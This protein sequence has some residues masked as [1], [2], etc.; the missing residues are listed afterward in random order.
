MRN[1]GLTRVILCAIICLLI[2]LPGS[3]ST[4]T[5]VVFGPQKY[6]RTTGAAD[7]YTAS[8]SIPKGV[9]SPFVLHVQNGSSYG[10]DRVSSGTVEIDGATILSQSDFNQQV[11]QFD[12]TVSLK[13][14]SVLRVLLTSSPGSYLTIWID[15]QR[16]D[17]TPPILKITAPLDASYVSKVTPH[18]GVEYSDLPGADEAAASG[19]D[20]TSLQVLL[21]GVNR[22]DWFTVRP[23]D[24]T[25]DVALDS[26]LSTGTHTL[27]V[28]IKDI[29]GN[30]AKTSASFRIDTTAPQISFTQPSQPWQKITNPTIALSYQDD[31][32]IDLSSLRVTINGEDRTSWFSVSDSSAVANLAPGALSNGPVEA[33]ATISDAAGN[34]SSTTLKFN[35]DIVK[36]SLTILHPS[37]GSIHASNSIDIAIA[38]SDDQA[39]DPSTATLTLDGSPIALQTGPM[40]AIAQ[41][42]TVADGQDHT[43]IAVVRDKAGNEATATSKFTVDTTNPDIHIVRPAVDEFSKTTAVT[44][45]VDYS[46]ADNVNPG[47]L[48]VLVNGIDR[49]AL[50]A[51]GSSSATANLPPGMLSDGTVVI[52][53]SVH[54]AAGNTGTTESHFVID[55]VAPAIS[56]QSPNSIVN[57]GA[58][59]IGVAY[60]DERSGV[61]LS[62]LRVSLDGQG[63]T[64]QLSIGP[65]EA[66]GGFTGLGDSSHTVS[67]SIKDKAGNQR[68]FSSSFVVDTVAPKIL[69]SAPVNDSFTNATAGDVNAAFDDQGGS[70]IVKSSVHAYLKHGDD[71]EQE[72]TDSLQ[73]SE[74]SLSGRL[75]AAA[76]LADGTYKLRIIA[77]DKATNPSESVTSFDVDT[78][79]PQASLESP[80]PDTS[81]SSK[82]PKITI[83]YRDDNSGVDLNRLAIRVDGN[84]LTS[85]FNLGLT[86]AVGELLPE[87][88]LA[89]GDH[90][91]DVALVDLAGNAGAVSNW[92]FR[93]DTVP[94]NLNSSISPAP[95]A[96]GWNNTDVVVTFA[97]TDP[98]DGISKC[99]DPVSVSTEGAGQSISGTAVDSA[100][101]QTILSVPVSIDRT[102]PVI[103]AVAS[104]TPN[105]AGWNNAD[106]T[107]TFTC[108]DAL[109]G[110]AACTQ[111]LSVVQ[112]SSANTVSGAALDVAG[113]TASAQVVVKLD[114]TPPTLQPVLSPAANAAGW[115]NTDVT[116]GFDCHDTLSGVSNCTGPL[117]ISQEDPG[118]TVAGSASD[119][120]GNTATTSVVVRIDKTPPVIHAVLSPL[121]NVAGWNNRDV[122]VSFECS[123]AESGVQTCPSPILISNDGAGQSFT[124]TVVDRAG[125]TATASGTVNIAKTLPLITAQL[126]PAPNAEGWN[127]ADVTVSFICSAGS[128]PISVCPAPVV[129]STEGQAQPVSGTVVD[130]AGNMATA[131][132]QVSIDKTPPVVTA[133]ATPPANAAGWNNSDVSVSYTCLDSLSGV[134]S[135]P[136]PITVNTE[137]S[138]QLFKQ[139]VTDRA[140]NAATVSTTINLDKTAPVITASTHPGPNSNGW[141]NDTVAVEFGCSDSLSGVAQCPTPMSVSAEGQ[142]QIVTGGAI[143]AAGNRAT[144]SAAV[145][146]DRT[147]PTV[148]VAAPNYLTRTTPAQI[149]VSADDNFGIGQMV[150]SVNGIVL[151][152]SSS[153]SS[154]FLLTVPSGAV[155]GD[156][157]NI[158]V[159]ATDLAGNTSTK[160][161]G[162]RVTAD[163]V[164]AGQVLSDV[165][166]LPLANARVEI[167]GKTSHDI[168][169]NHGRYSLSPGDLHVTLQIVSPDPNTGA[170][171]T[172]TV[173]RDVRIQAGAGVVPID[174]RLTPIAQPVTIPPDGKTITSGKLTLFIPGG[175]TG[176]VQFTPLSSQ[177]LPGLLPLGWSPVASWDVR[178]DGN[179][180][181]TL[182]ATK[183]ANGTMYLVSYSYAAHSWLMVQPNIETASDGSL[184]V[185][186][187]YSGTYALVVPDITDPPIAIAGV[188]QALVGVDF[189]TIPESVASNGVLNPAVLPPT[190]G[191]STATLSLQSAT[192]LPSGTVLQSTVAETYLPKSGNT[193]ATD[194]RVQDVVLYRYGA[195]Q[196]A[197]LGSAFPVT[198]SKTFQPADLISGKV[199]LDILAGRENVRGVPGGNDAVVVQNGDVTLTV[200]A[201]SLPQDTAVSVAPSEIESYLPSSSSVQALASI[202]VDF[203]GEILSSSAQL[204]IAA[205]TGVLDSDQLVVARVDRSI[206]AP[207]LIVVSAAAQQN[208]QLV[209]VV[210]AALPGIKQSGEYVFYRIANPIG[211]VAGAVRSSS[212]PV[213]AVVS[214]DALPF[215]FTTA[216]DGNFKLPAQVGIVKLTALVL[217]TALSG[218]AQTSV[219]AGQTAVQD[220]VVAGIVYVAQVSPADGTTRVATSTSII[221]TAPVAIAPNSVNLTNIQLSRV[222][223]QSPMAVRTILSQSG[224]A[225]SVIPSQQL[226]SGVKYAFSIAGLTDAVGAYISVPTVSFTTKTEVLPTFDPSQITF[227]YPDASGYVHISAPPG[228]F[229]PGTVIT[230]I[231]AGNGFVLSLT[232][233][234]D[235]SVSADM[236]ATI[237]DLLN[238]TVTDPLGAKSSF[239][240]SQFVAADGT[241]AVSSGGGT[242]SGPG[243]VELRIAPGTLDHAATFKITSFGPEAFED[244]PNTTLTFGG[245]LR[246]DANGQFSF[247]K[248]V[249]LAFPKPAGAPDNAVYFVFR[250]LHGDD[251]SILYETIDEAAVEGSGDAA[252]VVT[253]SPPHEGFVNLAT[254]FNSLTQTIQQGG[255]SVAANVEFLLEYA[256]DVVKSNFYPSGII[257]GRVRQIVNVPGQSS[258]TYTPVARALVRGVNEDLTQLG[259]KK[260]IVAVTQDNGMFTLWDESFHGGTVPLSVSADGMQP[261]TLNVTAYEVQQTDDSIASEVRGLINA[262]FGK[263][264]NVAYVDATYPAAPPKAPA[265]QLQISVLQNSSSGPPVLLQ[266]I[267]VA[268]T[269]LTIQV[270]ST[271]SDVVNI[272][273][274]DFFSGLSLSQDV[275]KG[276]SDAGGFVYLA[277]YLV[278][279]A[280]TF[281][282][283]ATS[284]PAFGGSAVIATYDF[285][286]VG[287]GQTPSNSTASP[288][289][290]TVIA[291][292]PNDSEEQIDIHVNPQVVFSEPVKNVS[293]ATVHVID[294]GGGDATPSCPA[295]VS[296]QLPITLTGI[297]KDGLAIPSLASSTEI[298]SLV[299]QPGQLLTYGH[300]YGVLL[301]QT[302]VDTDTDSNGAPAPKHLQSAVCIRIK[303]QN[304][305][306]VQGPTGFLSPGIFVD[307]NHAFV[308]EVD[309]DLDHG[310]A[311]VF[312]I[313]DPTHPVDANPSL[314]AV[315]DTFG[316]LILGRPMAIAGQSNS[317]VFSGTSQPLIAVAA[318]SFTYPRPSNVHLYTMN[319]AGTPI[320]VAAVSISAGPLDGMVND[321]AVKDGRVFASVWRKGIQVIDVQQAMLDYPWDYITHG[322]VPI[323]GYN[324]S[325]D[326]LFSGMNYQLYTE[327]KGFGTD[328]VVDTIPIVP[329]SAACQSPVPDPQ[330]PCQSEEYKALVYRIKTDDYVVDGQSGTWVIGAGYVQ[331]GSVEPS[332]TPTAA[333]VT[334]DSLSNKVYKTSPAVNNM[335]M[336]RAYVLDVASI[337][338]Q[339][340]PNLRKIAV[341]AG[342][343]A[344]STVLGVLQMDDPRAP[345]TLSLIPI[346]NEV[347][348]DLLVQ[349]TT[350]IVAFQHHVEFYD[351]T[352][353]YAPT[354]VGSVGNDSNPFGGHLAFNDD[355]GFLFSTNLN[356]SNLQDQPGLQ[357]AVFKNYVVIGYIPP[358]LS[359]EKSDGSSSPRKYRQNIVR[360]PISVETYPSTLK[361]ASTGTVMFYAGTRTSCPKSPDGTE[362]YAATVTLVPGS[363]THPISVPEQVFSSVAP[364]SEKYMTACAVVPGGSSLQPL[365]VH[366][367]PFTLGTVRVYADMNNDTKVDLSDGARDRNPS[368]SD[369]FA[370]W[371]SNPKN[372]PTTGT[373]TSTVDT[374]ET[375]AKPEAL[376]DYATLVVEAEALPPSG[377]NFDFG[378]SIQG[379]QWSV[380]SKVATQDD[381][382]EGPE[383]T[384]LEPSHVALNKKYLT[385]SATAQNQ[386]DAIN[387]GNS[388]CSTPQSTAPKGECVSNGPDGFI[389]LK[390]LQ[391]GDNVLL[392]RCESCGRAGTTNQQLQVVIKPSS[393]ANLVVSSINADLRPLEKWYTAY[394]VRGG[395]DYRPVPIAQKLEGYDDVPAEA[396]SITV[397]VHGFNVSE[398]DAT[399]NF[400]PTYF[401]RLY[402]AEHPVHT[403]QNGGSPTYVVGFSWSGDYL[404]SLSQETAAYVADLLLFRGDWSHSLHFPDDEMRAFESGVALAKL[405]HTLDADGR[406]L[407][408]VAHSLGNMVVNSA[409]TRTQELHG[410]QIANYVM[411]E[412]AV[413]TEAFAQEYVP[414]IEEST[415]MLPGAA[416]YGYAPP[417]PDGTPST[418]VDSRW[419]TDWSEMW[420][421]EPH[422]IS[423]D[424]FDFPDFAD[425]QDWCTKICG[426]SDLNVCANPVQARLSCPAAINT[427]PLPQY[428]Y[429]WS[430]VRPGGY[431]GD[432]PDTA[433]SNSPPQR[434]PWRGF[435]GKNRTKTRMINTFNT[436]DSVL[437]SWYTNR[438]IIPQTGPLGLFSDSRHQNFWAKLKNTGSEEDAI[439]GDGLTHSNIVRQWAELAYWF[440]PL[441][442]P[443]GSGPVPQIESSGGIN[444][445]LTSFGGTADESHSYLTIRTY[446]QVF[447]GWKKVS[448]YLRGMVPDCQPR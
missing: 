49:S 266:G 238:I 137:A 123:D 354:H 219:S 415:V 188:G 293:S 47:T 163:G 199:H 195:P 141:N 36:P 128:A 27:A 29:A 394:S 412:G 179:V 62:T 217:N 405:L 101:N 328:A 218:T 336:Q 117:T 165:T 132:V 118:W 212:G 404:S 84:N 422:R 342:T 316:G 374:R 285:R 221:V 389:S 348:T 46:D 426:T 313:S 130:A 379:A 442:G 30:E 280:G 119:F 154:D 41:A 260:Q 346:G 72:I 421:G 349:E 171:Q 138:A 207:R 61:D 159:E 116:V 2:A 321:V 396:K 357:G 224:T 369:R 387:S 381:Y 314:N 332:N 223:T 144:A 149:S 196:G 33:I 305:E 31:Q 83:K 323:L 102:I 139:T 59:T 161:R 63:V 76:P 54:D 435:F 243:G 448:A 140:G 311:R 68:D 111:T 437:Q 60:A 315:A 70:G 23:G 175:S 372:V 392:M 9:E 216:A 65:S 329:P 306:V 237:N 359:Q 401:K 294:L 384:H 11:Y 382:I 114:K 99:P 150:T 239:T 350:A 152:T 131:Q 247:K 407:N 310:R 380:T 234:N 213:G 82:S 190:G 160:S 97:C 19:I 71:Q 210:D 365:T 308:D 434:G 289:A 191:T 107:V 299:I 267:A 52:S 322:L 277:D 146:I 236:Q 278:P 276:P 271:T 258:P 92:H 180:V 318:N 135:C 186:T 353:P 80:A 168:T 50:F 431:E 246:V 334:V 18:L 295:T 338:S 251:G 214:T 233:L 200:P 14:G 440:S 366:P 226:E 3:A 215:V 157:L 176:S 433:D 341:V 183:L 1:N 32:K 56:L 297:G 22:T 5:T 51:R 201:G 446:P 202:Y 17:L 85:R 133:A 112:E 275:R 312:D 324:L 67:G 198:P 164:I 430:Q 360:I 155:P 265:P 151:G 333:V 192:S 417:N 10:A 330:N 147:A 148:N 74:T 418:N 282:I 143:D 169:D 416:N 227:S 263:F 355:G 120:A 86:S 439:F 4:S 21:D 166:G 261:A 193:L 344:S 398:E 79:A 220:I 409:L 158:S 178:G 362:V 232:V 228:S 390:D 375:R 331:P 55:T 174:A 413:P 307:K 58:V 363:T 125:N 95:N 142:N 77:T 269:T 319:N 57:T 438:V 48:K 402:W 134:E 268:D 428:A 255:S 254:S 414:S 388:L 153:G 42:Q 89:D 53:A 262:L 291:K 43:I 272:A 181:A 351:I 257:T 12:R 298:V 184:S 427:A 264:G 66:V 96:A 303:T 441:S 211:Y 281:R 327:G 411:N 75:G 156:T 361:L 38:Y 229:A 410:T 162:I 279:H 170:A 326:T 37:D 286:A 115:N 345:Q 104:P 378:L 242:V 203:S 245:G 73:V 20:T 222:D 436:N 16:R 7:V 425:V 194:P 105:A 429:R 90:S 399:G 126:S 337:T 400:F 25:A 358:I 15:G 296:N 383:G 304:P 377:S 256:T 339:S 300:W 122:T 423:N 235:G 98:G 197:A 317:P 40:G 106:V 129:V 406:T 127:N 244:R 145:S 420:A 288:D 231:D 371:D 64:N 292:T 284:I 340:A 253:L 368:D 259:N 113:N 444:C 182:T 28:S 34:P 103:T 109:S 13:Q 325:L 8:I 100:G 302:I 248:E 177:G 283:T 187:S 249:K 208:G 88:A 35:V 376:L 108:Q 205:P 136:A 290:P 167:L 172:I 230:I 225:L 110:I 347:P 26:P 250:R 352:N 364:L 274:Q 39:I 447:E 209:S 395:V 445:N 44:I 356:T 373:I 24:A 391:V 121:P 81:I 241:V 124:G 6:A 78:V 386:L 45:E 424:G 397:L 320:R 252:K 270:H 443:V 370:F 343:A 69:V 87:D 287:V 309:T 185:P 91:I 403:R 189:A 385:D 173:E 206:G 419:R 273:V 94:P 204:S 393:G 93:V 301:D 408:V 367:R 432:A 240:K 335:V